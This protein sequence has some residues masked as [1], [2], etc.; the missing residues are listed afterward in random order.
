MVILKD[1]KYKK[2]FVDKKS[3]GSLK[4]VKG[5]FSKRNIT[6][7]SA[8]SSKA[9]I[10]LYRA[11]LSAFE[12]GG[13]VLYVDTDSVFCAFP[14]SYCS[15]KF[16]DHLWLGEYVDGVFVSPKTYGLVK[17]DGSSVIKMKGVDCGDL[18][19][20]DLKSKFYS[21]GDLSFESQ[22][23]VSRK[24]FELRT[25]LGSKRIDLSL[26]DKRVFSLDKKT[27]S[28]IVYQ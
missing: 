20:G 22:F 21:N 24:D 17:S 26:Y 18:S 25:L 2:F 10:K 28:P 27:T 1:Y 12:S 8:I 7:A 11:M 3:V 14:L 9:R 16:G 15:K 5:E 6:Y 13:R 4:N 19:F 23:S